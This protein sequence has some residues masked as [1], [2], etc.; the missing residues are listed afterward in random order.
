M[1]GLHEAHRGETYKPPVWIA[2]LASIHKD[3]AFRE[4]KHGPPPGQ[5]EQKT[6]EKRPPRSE[7]EHEDEDRGE[8]KS[9]LVL[10]WFFL[11]M[12]IGLM[13]T[14]FLGIYMAFK[15]NRSRALLWTLLIAGAVI[16]VALIVMMT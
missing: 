16:P 1:F 11:A 6:E 3:Q 2:K 7:G 10:K 13:F 8:S 9:T 5:D 14:T 4:E 15:F 12:S